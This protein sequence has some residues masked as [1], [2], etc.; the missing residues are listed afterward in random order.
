MDCKLARVPRFCAGAIV[1]YSPSI[2]AIATVQVSEPARLR[3]RGVRDD[4]RFFGYALWGIMAHW[5]TGGDGLQ[6]WRR[7]P[8]DV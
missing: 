3:K 5:K 8:D 6:K 2:R 1:R 7:A 4:L